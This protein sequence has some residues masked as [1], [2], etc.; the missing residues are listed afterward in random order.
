MKKNRL[1]SIFLML[2]MSVVLILAGV[3]V[4]AQ[5]VYGEYA[6][7][8]G[9][10][11]LEIGKALAKV[12]ETGARPEDYVPPHWT[13]TD[14]A[15]GDLNGDGIED[16]AFTL[17]LDEKDAKYIESLKQLSPDASWIDQTFIIVVIDSRGDRK[18]H[19][20]T[21]NYNLYGDA[22]TPARNGDARD[23]F[24]LSMKQNVLSVKIEYGGSLR[25]SAT[26]LFREEKP[27]GGDLLLIG[28][29]YASFCVTPSNDCPG[30]RMSENY[31]TNTRVETNY[32][33][34]GARTVGANKQTQ[35]ASVKVEF[36]DARLNERNKKG[37]MRPF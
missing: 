9:L 33:L 22:E 28:F 18:L 34:Q 20:N 16:F 12:P 4:R 7:R 11:L 23:E 1:M 32:R 19:L 3:C 25:S 8:D 14:R 2:P 24:K 13:I 27:T 10:R 35:I 30:W 21:I 17:M 31:L 26:F 29:E 15:E 36:M 6:T 5:S 37:D